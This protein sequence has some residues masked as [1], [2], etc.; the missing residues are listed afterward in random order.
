MESPIHD[1][2]PEVLSVADTVDTE[3]SEADREPD[4]ESE[5]FQI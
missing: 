4:N 3:C 1:D 2:E 5:V